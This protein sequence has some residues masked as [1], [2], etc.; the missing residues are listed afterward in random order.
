MDE[1]DDDDDEETPPSATPTPDANPANDDSSTDTNDRASGAFDP[2]SPLYAENPNDSFSLF[3]TSESPYELLP[4]DEL[5]VG[6]ALTD[7]SKL[8]DD[9]GGYYDN[10]SALMILATGK[11]KLEDFVPSEESSMAG[12]ASSIIGGLLGAFAGGM[13]GGPAGAL[14]GLDIGADAGFELGA[15]AGELYEDLRDRGAALESLFENTRYQ[16]SPFDW[17]APQPNAT[18]DLAPPV[19]PDLIVGPLKLK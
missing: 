8:Y 4:K 13:M 3:P 9:A 1:D 16:P 12:L 15:A 10:E 18:P 5:D 6:S 17:P 19:Q 11:D 2:S 7:V 14:E